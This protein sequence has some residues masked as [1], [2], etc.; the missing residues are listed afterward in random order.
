MSQLADGRPFVVADLKCPA[1]RRPST[2]STKP[3]RRIHFSN[4][5]RCESP[6]RTPAWLPSARSVRAFGERLNVS[7]KI[8]PFIP[9]ASPT[10]V[11]ESRRPKRRAVPAGD[12]AGWD[13][14]I[15][16]GGF[17]EGLDFRDKRQLNF[18]N[19]VTP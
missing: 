15:V 2:A 16:A 7:L 17:A 13:R 9:F 6:R 19:Q 3:R 8:L 18:V 1:R 4:E 11:W 14:R 5:P 12:P 10:L